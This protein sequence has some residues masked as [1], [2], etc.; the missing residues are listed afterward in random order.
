MGKRTILLA[1]ILI[2]SAMSVIGIFMVAYMVPPKFS[3]AE[4]SQ[5]SPSLLGP[6]PAIG[7][8][9]FTAS[10]LVAPAA[11]AADTQCVGDLTNVGITGDLVVPNGASCALRNVTVRGDLLV[12]PGGALEVLGGVAVLGNVRIDQCAY[13]NVDPS[14]AA[15]GI[16]VAGN[17]EIE[18]C[19][20]TSGKRFTVGRVA[21]AGNFAC[22]DNAAPCFA[23][24]LT[25]GGDMLINRNSGSISYIEGNVIGGNLEC[26]GNVGVTDYGDP[27]TV[28]GEKLGECA[29]LSH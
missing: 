7:K 24:S 5:S 29:S 18:R 9:P 10:L 12:G 20:Q 8:S 22:H 21:I 26:V 15:A 6:P 27:N 28:R 17:V 2:L 16:S 13:A 11:R 3:S 19:T 4:T 25:I 1:L 14:T 23:V